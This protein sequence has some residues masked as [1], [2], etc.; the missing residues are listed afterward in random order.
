MTN[1]YPP[2]EIGN[3]PGPAYSFIPTNQV[4]ITQNTPTPNRIKDKVKAIIQLFEG[5][6]ST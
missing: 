6:P 3:V 4:Y 5:F 1:T 2:N